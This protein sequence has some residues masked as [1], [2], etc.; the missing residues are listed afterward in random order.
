MRVASRGEPT[1]QEAA[2]IG[3]PLAH[4]PV[5]FVGDETRRDFPSTRFRVGFRPLFYLFEFVHP[6][7]ATD[8]ATPHNGRVETAAFD[9]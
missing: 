2:Q 9:R 7:V 4:L 3:S 1:K 5:T 8:A 6:L